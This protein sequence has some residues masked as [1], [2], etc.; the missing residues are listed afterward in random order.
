MKADVFRFLEPT[1]KESEKV[2]L[3]RILSTK[4]EHILHFKFSTTLRSEGLRS[5]RQSSAKQK[6]VESSL[7][8]SATH[9]SQVVVLTLW[10]SFQE[11]HPHQ[12]CLAFSCQTTSLIDKGLKCLFFFVLCKKVRGHFVRICTK[13]PETDRKRSEIVRCPT[14]ISRPESVS[15]IWPPLKKKWYILKI[16]EITWKRVMKQLTVTRYFNSR[17]YAE[18]VTSVTSGA[19]QGPHSFNLVFVCLCVCLFVC[20]CH[21]WR[22]PVSDGKKS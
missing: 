21:A 10:A 9:L 14:V 11:E 4:R 5:Y 12:R 3:L 20:L 22:Y 7:S 8:Y 6:L 2:L 13:H 19:S 15:Q 17:S 16:E 1:T 18:D